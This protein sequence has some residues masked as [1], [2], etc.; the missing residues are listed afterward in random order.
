MIRAHQGVQHMKVVHL[1]TLDSGNGAVNAANQLHR[2][3]HRLGVDSTMFVAERHSM[4]TDPRVLLFNPSMD[5]HR[6]LLR[7]LRR[8]QIT[9][10]LARYRTSRPQGSGAFSDDR[11]PYG[12]DLLAQLPPCD[13]INIHAMFNFIDYQTFFTT[14]PQHTPVVRTLHDMNFFTGGCHYAR[15][16]D[17]FTASCGTCPQLGSHQ[18]VDLSRHIWQRKQAALQSVAPGCLHVVTP[19]HWLANEA[20]RSPLLRHF[21]ITTIPYGVDTESF[22]PRER[23]IAREILGIP[24]DAQVVLFVASPLARPEKGFALLVQALEG[25]AH[26]PDLL[27]LIVGNGQP[28]VEVKVSHLQ[29]GYIGNKRLLSLVYSATDVFAIPSLQD[30]QPQTVLEALACGTPVVGFAVGGIPDMVRPGVTGLLAPPQDVVAL[31]SAIRELLHE[32]ASRA[33]LA[34]NCRRVAVEEYNLELSAQRYRDLYQTILA[35]H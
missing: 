1:S 20:Q 22:C 18:E 35:S 32:P 21:P 7:R 28:P 33:A 12:A 34:A 10:S 9:R 5:L 2:S 13:V 26:L 17:K 19:S 11:S 3:L 27:L 29:L 25:L 15:D 14:V 16:C 23:G 31:R 6:R 30:N 24:P 4:I 8:K